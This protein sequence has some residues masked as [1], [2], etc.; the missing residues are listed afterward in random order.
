VGIV[1]GA[2][3]EPYLV[4]W[5]LNNFLADYDFGHITLG[6]IKVVHCLVLGQKS[7]YPF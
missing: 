4:L 2:L 7:T 6:Q 1:S 5:I 3:I